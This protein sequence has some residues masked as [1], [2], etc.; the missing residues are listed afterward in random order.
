MNDKEA[1][2]AIT[3][4]L[5]ER[6]MQLAKVVA[7]CALFG[8]DMSRLC[9][10]LIAKWQAEDERGHND[11]LTRHGLADLKAPI[12]SPMQQDE[13][14]LL[15]EL[16]DEL[17]R[18]AAALWRKENPD[19]SVFACTAEEKMTYRR[20]VLTDA[21]EPEVEIVA[22]CPCGKPLHECTAGFGP[23]RRGEPA[24]CLGEKS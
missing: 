6:V 22:V 23:R 11:W 1:I 8:S 12:P 14:P 2:A 16:S 17:E 24:A 7:Q 5:D 4:H 18:A 10:A 21:A 13:Q 19:K 9:N 20:R 3:H 15:F